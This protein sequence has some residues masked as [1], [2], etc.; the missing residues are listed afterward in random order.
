MNQST[1]A[2]LLACGFVSA[3]AGLFIAVNAATEPSPAKQLDHGTKNKLPP[4]PERFHGHWIN[5]RGS[6]LDLKEHDG[7]LSGYFT[8]AVGKTRSCIGSPVAINGTTNM[9]VMSLSLS[10]A[11]CGSPAVIS[12]TGI[13]MKD[14]EGKEMLKTQALIQFSGRENWDSQI[15]TTDFYTQYELDEKPKP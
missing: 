8:T 5:Q 1:V 13:I 10:M 9:N 11:S 7:L 15:L 4:H 2:R 14:H 12:M 3:S 6:T